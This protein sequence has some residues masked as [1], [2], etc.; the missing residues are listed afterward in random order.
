MG[1]VYGNG[2][3]ESQEEREILIANLSEIQKQINKIHGKGTVQMLSDAPMDVPRLSTGV[4]ALDEKLDGGFPLGKI[5]EIFGPES[6]GKSSI[7]LRAVGEAQKLGEC[8]F[9]DAENALDPFKAENSNIDLDKLLVSQLSSMEK[10]LEMI[11]LAV[12]ADDTSLIVVDSQAALVPE[13]EIHGEMGDV[14]MGLI[15]RLMSQGLRKINETMNQN[16]SQAVVIFINQIREKLGT[17]GFGPTTTTPGGRA[18]KFWSATRLDVRRIGALKQGEDII[19]Q[20][21]RVKIAKAKFS[22]PFQQTNF[23]IHYQHGVQ[24]EATLID[25][26]KDAGYITQNGSWFKNMISDENLAQGRQGTIDFLRENPEICDSLKG[27]VLQ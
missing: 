12:S 10:V 18:L 4:L 13:A 6:G 7:G 22:R 1:R 27:K 11:D 14:H 24:N 19:G 23:E 5:V 3:R 9:I 25:L 17:Q 8:L 16:N 15:G 2:E 21:V 26:A 20:E